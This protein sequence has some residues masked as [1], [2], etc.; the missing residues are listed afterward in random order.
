[1][2]NMIKLYIKEDQLHMKEKV[3]KNQK[4]RNNKSYKDNNNKNKRNNNYK[5]IHHK[6]F[7]KLNN[8][9]VQNL[10]KMYLCHLMKH[11]DFIIDNLIK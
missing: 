6:K 10:I 9:N 11:M 1:M 2:E 3:Q 5:L 7:N 8:I 4:K